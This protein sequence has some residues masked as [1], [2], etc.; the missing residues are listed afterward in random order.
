MKGYKS[1]DQLITI[2]GRA[3]TIHIKSLILNTDYGDLD[4]VTISR[5]WPADNFGRH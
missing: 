3:R 2:R 1:L 5:V 4:P